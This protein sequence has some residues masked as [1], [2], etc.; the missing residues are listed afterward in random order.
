MIRQ[1]LMEGP[2]MHM[3]HPFDLATVQNGEDLLEFFV[4]KDGNP[5]LP[6]QYIN[7]FTPSIKIDGINGPIRL[8][9]NNSGEKEFAIDRMSRASIDVEGVT[10]DRLKE[11]FEKAILQALDTDE[12]IE[13]PLHKLVA[14]GIPMDKLKIGTNLTI[15]H[16]KKKKPVIIK[17][18]T[19]GHGFVNDGTVALTV[20]NNALNSKPQEMEAIL[21]IL[22]MW[23]NP[24]VCLNNDIVHESSK[25]DGQVG[26]VKYGED[27][28]AFHGLNEIYS[29]EGKTTRKT[30]EIRINDQQKT[31]L[32]ELVRIIN[33]TNTIEGFRAL[34][35]FDTVAM[36]GEL[37]IDYSGV[38]GTIIEIK[39]DS[40]TSTSQALS[41]W[42]NDP[43]IVKPSYSTKYTFADGKKKS[44][45]S[46]I[47]YVS[48]IPDQGEQQYSI[49]DL[50]SEEV[51][52]DLDEDIYYNFASGAIFYHATRL[53][54]RVVLQTLVNK[55]KVGNEALTSHEGIVMRSEALFDVDKPIKIT[56]DFI[57]DGMGSNLA[58]AMTKKPASLNESSGLQDTVEGELGDEP[59]EQTVVTTTGTRTVA[60]MPGSFKPP[61]KG[62][63]L[64]AEHLS[65]IADEVLIFVSAPKGSKRLLPFS[66]TEITYEKAI[67]L[68]NLLLK[69]ASGNIK[70]VDSSSPSSSPITALAEI[71]QPA[72]Q[73]NN[74]QDVDFYPEEYSKFFLAMSEKERNDPGSMGRFSF[75]EEMENVEIKL[76]PAFNHDPEY[77]QSIAELMSSSVELIKQISD[78]VEL[79]ALELAKGLVSSKGQKRLPANPSIQDYISVLSK[80]NQKKVAKF[81]KST[82]SGLDKNNFSATDL[83][84]LLD[85]K[86]VYNLPVDSLLKDFVG[87]NLEDY[88]RIIFGS[89]EVKESI[90]VIQDM[91]KSILAEQLEETATM[92]SGAV[93]IGGSKPEPN[94]DDDEEDDVKEAKYHPSELPIQNPRGSSYMT[95]K[96][97]PHG[98]YA[99]D[100]NVS[101]AGFKKHVKNRFKIDSTYTDKRAPYYDKDDIITDLVE[102][103][104]HNIIRL[105]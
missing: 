12:V 74:Y 96:V 35:P 37:D 95:V 54:G 76:V 84:L 32:T 42:L 41:A 105:N 88:L 18:I 39:L 100:G 98:K 104:L 97:I 73:R 89:G 34:S 92:A 67:E 46:K 33:E 65:G 17:K 43:K 48:L 13:I 103:V 93:H 29:P 45:F 9:V 71:M 20:L 57:R 14:M 21:K 7:K 47:N 51:H 60:V 31:A 72:D 16:R 15:I 80:S 55:S 85:L 4:G 26:S 102:K 27:F 59:E 36:K 40:Q 44:S 2:S 68:W 19:S 8:V 75:Y 90:T 38:L 70:V 94:R 78:D 63:L 99:V 62:H 58:L 61:H 81:M 11:R 66:G 69:G 79:K 23:N 56:G 22:D 24:N 86:K 50:L 77:G 87:Q 28:I 82:P 25:P 91:V 101:D 5:G 52:P 1:L 10:A 49:R 64:M 53:L 83:R 6:E 3:W 30:K